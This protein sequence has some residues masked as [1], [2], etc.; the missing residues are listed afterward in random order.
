[1]EP[2]NS[3][4][5]SIIPQICWLRAG[6]AICDELEVLMIADEVITGFGRTGRWFAVE[7][8][9]VV[10]DL[11][12]VAKGITSGYIRLSASIAR[13]HLADALP[14]GSGRA[15]VHLNAYAAQPAR[16]SARLVT[17]QTIEKRD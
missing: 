3:T 13:Q 10:P 15:N 12:S 14:R 11:M 9:G 7:H 1:M 6:R 5:G 2:I 16:S 4:G 17:I 8:D